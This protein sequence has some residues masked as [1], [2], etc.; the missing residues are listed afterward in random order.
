MPDYDEARRDSAQD[1]SSR[2]EWSAKRAANA[3]SSNA[4]TPKSDEPPADMAPNNPGSH[5]V[6]C[7]PPAPYHARNA[8]TFEM[9]DEGYKLF[10]LI[11][12]SAVNDWL[13]QRTK[14]LARVCRIHS[15]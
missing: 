7:A 5:S 8:I 12:P 11:V 15:R 10:Q 3:A 4:E 9:Y 14:R 2:D 1:R 6:A 13:Y